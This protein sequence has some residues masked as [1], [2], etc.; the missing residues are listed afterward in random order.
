MLTARECSFSNWIVGFILIFTG[1]FWPARI[2]S[3][4]VSKRLYAYSQ[5][6]W[7]PIRGGGIIDGIIDVL[8]KVEHVGNNMNINRQHS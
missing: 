6:R 8:S 7:P 3:A 2:P 1:L 5:F 4:K